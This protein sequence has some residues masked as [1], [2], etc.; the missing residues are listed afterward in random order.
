MTNCKKTVVQIGLQDI[1]INGAS[2]WFKKDSTRLVVGSHAPQARKLQF[3]DELLLTTKRLFKRLYEGGFEHCQKKD[4]RP[5][6][7]NQLIR[8][9]S[10]KC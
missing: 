6:I 8:D 2:D 10:S 1:D 7:E 4:D 9:F 3:L 5:K